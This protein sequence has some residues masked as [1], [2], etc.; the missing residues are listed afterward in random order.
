MGDMKQLLI[1]IDI[2]AMLEDEKQNGPYY[3]TVQ[4]I[5]DAAVTCNTCDT[6]TTISYS[7]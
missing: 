3:S 5:N 4:T 2:P 6:H 7:V 1:T